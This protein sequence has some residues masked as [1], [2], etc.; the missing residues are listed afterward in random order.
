M[1]INKDDVIQKVKL[2]TTKNN[3]VAIFKFGAKIKVLALD[4]TVDK[5]IKSGYNLIGVYD[6]KVPDEYIIED[7]EYCF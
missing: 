3:K 5:M 7:L 1:I 6:S 2:F 4:K